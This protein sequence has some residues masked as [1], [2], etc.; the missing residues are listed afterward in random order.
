MNKVLEIACDRLESRIVDEIETFAKTAGLWDSWSNAVSF[1]PSAQKDSFNAKETE[2]KRL[3][4][5]GAQGLDK[6]KATPSNPIAYQGQPDYGV[7]QAQAASKASK[8]VT[9]PAAAP[10][11]VAERPGA[12]ASANKAGATGT[13]ENY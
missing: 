13:G 11:Q 10:T 1:Q 3:G 12:G 4:F 5:G 9:P 2:G 7:S 6:A 8:P